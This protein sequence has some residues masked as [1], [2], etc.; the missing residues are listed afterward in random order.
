MENKLSSVIETAFSKLAFTIKQHSP[1]IL[2]TVGVVG[3]IAG[4]V[5]ACV[6]TTKVESTVEQRKEAIDEAKNDISEG[7]EDGKKELVKAYSGMAMDILKLY[8]IPTSIEVVSIGCIL[9]SNGILK[10]RN[11]TMCASYAALVNSFKG[12]RARVKDR[13]GEDEERRI[14]Y[15]MEVSD[16]E[17][18]EN[19]TE[20]V[21]ENKVN[22]Y[23][24]YS[25]FYDCTNPDWTDS[26]EYNKMHILAIQNYWN[27]QLQIR[28]FVF[29][30]EVY[31]MLGFEKT[32]AGQVVGW[33]YDPSNEK[34]DNYIDFGI[35]DVT[36]KGA[37][38]FVNG[39]ENVILLD[40]NVDGE[41]LDLCELERA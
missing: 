6:A 41:I 7:K 1:E 26:A 4:A 21:D 13:L 39:V 24:P 28:G 5:T 30:N 18:E 27:N 11:L 31:E 23:S 20:I 10:Q 9:A 2:M 3:V 15:N 35:Y 38:E 36:K 40:F 17:G 34:S 25:R 19:E 8:A 14:M 29:L 33:I 16:K 37:R 32:K 12:Y 22:D